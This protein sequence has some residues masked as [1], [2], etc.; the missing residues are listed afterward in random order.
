MVDSKVRLGVTGSQI[1]DLGGNGALAPILTQLGGAKGG[2]MAMDYARQM[3]PDAPEA[4]PW[5]AALQFF[6]EM[7]RGAS[8]PGATVVGSAVGAAQAPVDYLNAKKK[9]KTETDRARMQTALQ[10]AP[11]L[12]PKAGTYKDPKEYSISM[13]IK[14]DDGN[15]TGYETAY[16]DFLTAKD[17]AKL[18]A[19][20]ARF[21]SVPK[22]P[23]TSTGS[24][25][26]G[27]DPDNLP[28]LRLLLNLPNLNVDENNNAVIPNS[29]VKAA[30]AE[31][32]ILPKQAAPKEGVEKYLQQDRVLYLTKEDAKKKLA[33][34]GVNEDDTEYE[35]LIGLITTDDKN[36]IGRPVIQADSYINYYIPRA[37]EKSEFNVVT[38][39][40]GGS[41][42]PAE[43]LARN[44][45]IKGLSKIAIKQNQVMNDLLPT[46]DSAM[47]VLLQN[48]DVT[49]AFQNFT[50]PIRSFMSSSFGFSDSELESQRYLE[51]ISNKLAPQMR[52]VGSGATSDMEFRAYKSAILTME[53]PAVSNYLT[54]YSLDKT[55]RNA[56][57]ELQLRRKLL[58]QN[59]SMT[60]IEDKVLELDKGIYE[61]FEAPTDDISMEDYMAAR[62]SWK[63]SLPNGAVILNKDSSGN[64]IYPNAGTFIIKGWGN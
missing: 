61:K 12:K 16:T 19:E 58:T 44:E 4:D 64:K 2:Q 31:G 14:D 21:T 8:Q 55:T 32:L 46:L 53:N 22:A 24:T 43:V 3:Y 29:A 41:P 50:M 11:S 20:G 56:Q 51:A 54:L 57:K 49:G 34:L 28:A 6:L 40:P 26:V 17:F 9:E 45:E 13:P 62:D 60:Y 25:T 5:E 18:Q 15:I 59:K 36:L 10:L 1:G 38:R 48:Q 23:S 39:T 52:P 63:A 7:G 33:T 47:T 37:G 27:I 35:G 42:V 30:T